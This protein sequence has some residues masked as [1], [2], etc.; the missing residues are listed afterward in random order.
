MRNLRETSSPVLSGL[1]GS[2]G[3]CFGGCTCSITMHEGRVIQSRS[4]RS[5]LA[6][7]QTIAA[8]PA[9]KGRVWI[10]QE[11]SPADTL[12]RPLARKP[13][14]SRARKWGSVRACDLRG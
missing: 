12:D 14:F 10:T 1:E 4:P 8:D 9:F 11:R 6:E 2:C 3:G 5:V 13:C 7:V